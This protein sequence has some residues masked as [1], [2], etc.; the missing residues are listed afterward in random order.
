MT[1]TTC[2]CF[3][4]SFMPWLGGSCWLAIGWKMFEINGSGYRFYVFSYD[5][6]VL[7]DGHLY[8]D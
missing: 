5:A 3:V 1:T 4:R 6:V 7:G 2:A 8:R